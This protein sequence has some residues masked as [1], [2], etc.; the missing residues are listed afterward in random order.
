[1]TLR[2]IGSSSAGNAYL[3]DGKNESLLIECGVPFGKVEKAV[4]FAFSKVKG[5]IVSHEHGDHAK[6]IGKCQERRIPVYASKGT[7]DA[8]GVTGDCHVMEHHKMIRIG[9]F[10][11]IPF[12]VVHDA[13]EPFGFLINHAEMGTMVFATD[14]AYLPSK[15]AGLNH[16]MIECNYSTSILDENMKRGA[17]LP[18]VRDRIVK[19]HMSLDTCLETLAAN[20]LSQVRNIILI[21]LSDGNSNAAMFRE[22]VERNTGIITTIAEPGVNVELNINPSF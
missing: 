5:V 3:L 8:I 2:I 4:N 13:N 21:H 9:G 11:V 22:I 7:L 19:S 17:I 10:G 18:M 14:T 20:D 15:F 6:G 16:M 12:K 1:M